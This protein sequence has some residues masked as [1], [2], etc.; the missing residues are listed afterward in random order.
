MEVAFQIASPL[1]MANAYVTPP[2]PSRRAYQTPPSEPGLSIDNLM[3]A[4]DAGILSKDDVRQKI[5][6]WKPPPPPPLVSAPPPPPQPRPPGV[7]P[8]KRG[9]EN[10][11]NNGNN[12]K[13][14]PGKPDNIGATLR[15]I[16]RNP[17]RRRF[18]N[19]CCDPNS[20]LWST[21]AAGDESVD[22]ALLDAAAEDPIQL[23]YSDNP[24]ATRL[25]NRQDLLHKVK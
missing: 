23:I 5:M 18:F 11:G 21:N 24:G 16:S 8:G 2:N 3:R 13:R 25:V 22:Q 9:R 20:L 1:R 19:Q 17:T 4:Y 6:D 10:N 15:R 7:K 12:K 14:R